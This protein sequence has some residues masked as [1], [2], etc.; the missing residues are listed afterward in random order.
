[1]E[2]GNRLSV[3]ILT[4][5]RVEEVTR[6]VERMRALPERLPIVVVDNAST[7][8][9]PILLK[10]RFPE[11][12]VITLSCNLG[13][14]GRNAGVCAVATL[15]VAFCD[16]DT[17]WAPGSLTRAAMLLDAHPCVAVLSA[18]VLV[19]PDE[20]EDPACAIMAAS[21]LPSADLPGRS[22]LGFLA[23]AS[24]MRRS[25]FLSV[26]GYEP[27]FFLGGEEALLALDL[28]AQGWALVYA[29]GLTVHHYPSLHRDAAERK[30]LLARN[31]I[32]VAWL[33]RPFISAI[34]ETLHV[35]RAARTEGMLALCCIEAA[36]GL[37]WVLH[38][39]RV[40]PA[41]V[42]AMCRQTKESGY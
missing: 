9:T 21:S 42:E 15:Y 10:R 27:R 13:A 1:M 30:Q 29:D 11:I 35:L 14:A 34:R 24:V 26:G 8:R 19:G 31:S 22:V 18:R 4:H 28:A 17:W 25:A 37:R 5:N 36:R 2:L 38:N 16:D 3:V 39:R 40:V 23:G 33:R 41:E 12:E 32:W 7:D 6:T 20:R